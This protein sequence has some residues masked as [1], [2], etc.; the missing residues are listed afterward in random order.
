M[1]Q[2][3][4]LLFISFVI[5]L[6]FVGCQ[7]APSASPTRSFTQEARASLTATSNPTSTPT[8]TSLPTEGS[9]IISKQRLFCTLLGEYKHC[10]DRTLNIEFEHP[11][12]WGEIEGVLRTGWDSGYAYKYFFSNPAISE[13]YLPKTGG[14]SVDFAEGREHIPLDFA[15][16]GSNGFQENS[17]EQKDLYPICNEVSPAIRWMIRFPNANHYC[18]Y[19]HRNTSPIIRIEINLPEHPQINGFVFEVPFLSE[20]LFEEVKK[21]I[22]SLFLV[23][24]ELMPVYPEACYPENRQP[25][26]HQVMKFIERVR[27]RS[28]D[29]ETLMNI[30]QLTHLAESIEIR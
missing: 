21:D 10:I 8:L 26:D 27:T 12:E 14:I 17:C 16:F 9:R 29:A 24:P 19:S 5:G 28:V 6:S 15:G 2:N 3:I 11:S 4:S 7:P 20:S 30:D 25:F 13:D 22:Y 18:E 1:K 23:E